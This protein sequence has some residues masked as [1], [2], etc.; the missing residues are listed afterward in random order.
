MKIIKNDNF[1]IN[2]FQ[3]DPIYQVVDDNN[4]IIFNAVTEKE[5]I[6]F[7]ESLEKDGN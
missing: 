4:A 3:S 1:L 2:V 6:L 7:L 5:C